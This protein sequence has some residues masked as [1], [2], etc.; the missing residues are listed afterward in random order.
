[1]ETFS[2]DNYISL[3]RGYGLEILEAIKKAEKSVKIVSPYLS[4]SYLEELVKLSEKGI[5]ITLITSDNLTESSNTFSNFRDSDIIK[6]EKIQNPNVENPN[7]KR[8]KQ[9]LRLT[10]LICFLISITTFVFSAFLNFLIYLAII[11]AFIG[12]IALVFSYFI[13]NYSKN[14]SYKYYSIFRLKVF[15]SASGPNPQSTNLIHSKIF[16]IDEKTAYLGS[17][18]FTYSGFKIHY[19]TVIKIKDPKAI[20]DIS[21]EVENLFISTELKAKSIDDWGREI[22]G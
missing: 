1:M 17:A 20:S 8:Q 18:N 14:Y 22:Y 2:K 3:G 7:A 21:Q 5:K 15:D 16:I 4:A 6:Q 11:L 13:E 9:N 19:E 12:A 10:S